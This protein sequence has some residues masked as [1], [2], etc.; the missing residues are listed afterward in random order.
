MSFIYSDIVGLVPKFFFGI[1][2][3]IKGNVH[4]ITEEE[5]IYPNGGVLVVHNFPGKRQ[6]YIKLPEKG[7][8]VNLIVLSPNR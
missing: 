5:V 7:Y 8:N 1:N 3:Q 2:T 6:K 4:Y